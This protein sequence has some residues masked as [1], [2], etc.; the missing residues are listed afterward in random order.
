MIGLVRQ[1]LLSG[2]KAVDQFQK[3]KIFHS[4]CLRSFDRQLGNKAHVK[5]SMVTAGK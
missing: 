5:A 3:L 1:E 4:G 2:I